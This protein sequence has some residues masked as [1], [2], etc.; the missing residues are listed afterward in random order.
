MSDD[1]HYLEDAE[2]LG[3]ILV[4]GTLSLVFVTLG[5]TLWLGMQLVALIG[6]LV[7][8]LRKGKDNGFELYRT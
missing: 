2:S 7:T 3:V 4:V 1:H 6:G 8:W 5:A